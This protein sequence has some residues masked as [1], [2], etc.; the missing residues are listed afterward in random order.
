ML[1]FPVLL[2]LAKYKETARLHLR[3]KTSLCQCEGPLLNSRTAMDDTPLLLSGGILANAAEAT[4]EGGSIIFYCIA[5]V[6]LN[7]KCSPLQLLFFF[8]NFNLLKNKE[9]Q[10]S[11]RVSTIG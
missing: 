5:F 8:F 1:P 2:P 3:D 9:Q 10:N 7:Q 6:F 4:K 11:S